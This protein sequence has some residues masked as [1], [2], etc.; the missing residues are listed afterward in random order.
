MLKP[1]F[2]RASPGTANLAYT[3]CLWKQ[4]ERQKSNHLAFENVNVVLKRSNSNDLKLKFVPNVNKE[5]HS[6]Y[7]L[8]DVFYHRLG[9]IESLVN[10]NSLKSIF[11]LYRCLITEREGAAKSSNIAA[12][13]P[14]IATK[15]SNIAAKSLNDAA[16]LSKIVAESFYLFNFSETTPFQSPFSPL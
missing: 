12:K 9:F 8:F 11:I 1:P 13:L 5:F 7:F 16:K 10:C 3:H 14:N 4:F 15:L 2:Y 6:W